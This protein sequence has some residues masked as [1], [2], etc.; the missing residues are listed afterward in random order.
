M[1]QPG[2]V[3]YLKYHSGAVRGVAFH[4]KDRYLFCSGSYDGKV[5]LYSAQ[6]CEFLMS[7]AVTTVSLARNVNAVRF[8]SDGSK[9]LATTT[10]RR[11]AV[12]DLQRGDQ[13]LSYD[14]CAFNGRDRTG[15]ACDPLAPNIAVCCCVNG[16]GLTVFDLRMPLPL[17]FMYDIH[18]S[19]IRDITFVHDS[20]PWGQGQRSI[21]SV[22]QDGKCRVMSLDGRCLDQLDFGQPLN[23][24]AVT[25]E[26]FNSG[27]DDGFSSLIVAGGESVSA[28]IPDSGICETLPHNHQL[29]IWKLRYT[30]NGSI[31]Y[32]A[33]DDGAIRKYRRWPDHHAYIEDLFSHKQDV[34]DM[35]IS[36][37]DEY[38]VTASKDQ[39]VGIIK[40]GAP[41][42]GSSE[43]G[44]LT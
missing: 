34:E 20:W 25:P 43:W 29:P 6:K 22:S 17:D 21:M 3:Q 38:L 2:T 27:L 9:I 10:A 35:D 8:T 14:N 26:S 36:P 4:P 24:V 15:L 40:L 23:T 44:E 33:C 39:S 5:N 31:L 12:I 32:T 1:Q 37:Y 30:S 7:Y 28:Y 18:S 42:H 19:I 41:N 11:L 13:I 16:R